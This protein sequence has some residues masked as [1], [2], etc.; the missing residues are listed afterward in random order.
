MFLVVPFFIT[1]IAFLF[2]F[3]FRSNAINNDSKK[4]LY[5]EVYISTAAILNADRDFY[6]AAIAEKEL[7]LRG[8]L[9]ASDQK[10]AYIADYEENAQQV[11]ER[12][13]TALSNVSY[14]AELYTNYPHEATGRTLEQ[15]GASFFQN[16]STWNNL[17]DHQSNTGDMDAKSIVFEE[18]RE[19]INQMTEILESYA[20]KRSSDILQ[21]VQSS[22]TMTIIVIASIIVLLSLLA[23]YLILSI[24]GNIRYATDFSRRIAS[25]ES[26]LEIDS[27]KLTNDEIGRLT[28]TINN[29]VRQAFASIEKARRDIDTAADQVA[30]GTR[31]VSEG[32]QAIALGATE[33][34][35]S[36][37]QLTASV[38]QIAAQTKQNAASAD[39]ANQLSV[40]ARDYAVKGNEQMQDM[41]TAMEQIND[42]SANISKIIRVIDDIAFQTNILALNAAV[43]AARAGA[44]GKGFAVV[45]EEVRNLAAKSAD[46]VK[47]TTTLIEGSIER[48]KAGTKIADDTAGALKNIVHSV[49]EA[50]ELVSEIAAA[51]VEQATAIAQINSGLEQLS[52]VVQANS[53]TAEETAAASEELS[54]QAEMLREMV[55]MLEIS[56]T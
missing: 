56:G 27:S 28:K 18:A 24:R 30:S 15:I 12:I 50:L 5:D 55:D 1:L 34:A 39:R 31:Q 2:Y 46:A 8:D 32:S 36:L 37:E 20:N 52:K 9:I 42:S 6:Q 17:Y 45:A 54:S 51:S 3:N 38:A 23:L 33:Q 13:T 16:F 40:A 47:E 21:Q 25:G 44:H 29:E 41:Q 10:E 48:V 14:N 19:E 49:E 53:A 22:I 11:Y 7:F 35:S 43:E 26:G 4:A